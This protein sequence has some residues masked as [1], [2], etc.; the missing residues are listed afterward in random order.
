MKSIDIVVQI[1]L[2][3]V[4]T[5]WA[6]ENGVRPDHCLICGKKIKNPD[7]AKTVHLLT[8][9]NLIS[10]SEDFEDSQGGFPV[11]ADCAKRL[12]VRFAW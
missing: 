12:V 6:K 1:P 5:D 8:N 11:G 4:Q 2:E 7:S 9:G 10:S 3:S